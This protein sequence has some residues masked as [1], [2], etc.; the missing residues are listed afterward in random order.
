[1]YKIEYRADI[2]GLRAIAVMMVVG[3]HAGITGF[4]GGFLGVDVFFV[5]SG[6]LIGRILLKVLSEGV[7]GL[8]GF[9]W[10]RFRRILPLQLFVIALALVAGIVLFSPR[11][12][13]D[14]AQS[15]LAAMFFMSNI[16]FY[17]EA[18]YFSAQAGLKPL[19]HT[20]SL[21]IEEQFYLLLPLLLLFQRRLCRL[22]GYLLLAFALMS[23]GWLWLNVGEKG[24]FYLLQFRAWQLLA[25][26]GIAY[27]LQHRMPLQVPS[28][29]PV[30]AVTLLLTLMLVYQK[31][32]PAPSWVNLMAVVLAALLL[33][34]QTSRSWLN[35]SMLV[36]TGQRS[37]GI[38]L[39]H[40]PVF[41]CFRHW[42][43]L[44]PDPLEI[45]LGILL[46]L[47]LAAA[48]FQRIE[49]FYRY[50][51]SSKQ[52][53]LW[54]G[55]LLVL[56]IAL[57]IFILMSKGH[58]S[59]NNYALPV[60]HV[61]DLRQNGQV[62]FS[63]TS[64]PCQ[65]QQPD[66]T[67]LYLVG[68]SHAATLALPLSQSSDFG[69]VDLTMEG[70]QP[71]VQFYRQR[72]ACTLRYQQYRL[73]YLRSAPAGVVVLLGRLPLN[74]SESGASNQGVIEQVPPIKFIRAGDGAS[75]KEQPA[76]LQ[77]DLQ[78]LVDLLEAAGHRI[79]IVY[80]VPEFAFHVPDA[81]YQQQ[82]FGNMELS[83]T[84]DSKIF[85]QRVRQSYQLFDSLQG[86]RVLR[87]FPQQ[88]I[89]QAGQGNCQATDPRLLYF[90][91][92]HLSLAGSE[93]LVQLIH[94]TV[95]GEW[96]ELSRYNLKSP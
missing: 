59:W 81:F 87:V 31:D 60:S 94:Q 32:W 79:V 2:D 64:Q 41:A 9:W 28:W 1:M 75:A 95:F 52:V 58:L 29:L 24:T 66:K 35:G 38:Y 17:R 23:L 45:T 93:R 56:N 69:L 89:C 48:T 51:S 57:V 40:F 76:A 85:A 88:M 42:S 18:D 50:R 74:L 33:A 84:L 5:I 10:R 7:T 67:P 68:D 11:Y 61:G 47:L 72:G 15:A 63:R 34:T 54:T 25:G 46:T 27:F 65:W 26:V 44:A 6:Y 13:E 82:R 8:P 86:S 78:T 77:H 36:W 71:A 73:E 12:L 53:L 92:D 20:W 91:D 39:W 3:Y 30:M 21:A 70:C 14:L 62:C 22:T 49:E 80:P 55:C 83:L 16:L 96:P 43:Q 90:D 4:S 37:Y 19:L